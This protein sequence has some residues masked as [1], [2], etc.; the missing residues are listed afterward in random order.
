MWGEEQTLGEGL[1]VA[2]V[3]GVLWRAE[4]TRLA[5]LRLRC[6]DGDVGGGGIDRVLGDEEAKGKERERWANEMKGGRREGGMSVEG[7][8][9]G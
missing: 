8:G 9:G 4:S 3:V 7:E 2:K 1:E 5:G 6:H